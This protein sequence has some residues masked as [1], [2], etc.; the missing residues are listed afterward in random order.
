MNYYLKLL[1]L[2]ADTVTILCMALLVT[3]SY[4]VGVVTTF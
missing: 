4:M 2:K 3:I 1:S